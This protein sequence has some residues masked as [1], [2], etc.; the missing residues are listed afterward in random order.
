MVR[1][2]I[3][4]CKGYAESTTAVGQ[5]NPRA[6]GMYVV[7]SANTRLALALHAAQQVRQDLVRCVAPT[8]GRLAVQRLYAH[9]LHERVHAAAA[10]LVALPAQQARRHLRTGERKLHVPF[11]DSP[12]Q[13]RFGFADRLRPVIR[14]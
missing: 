9:T 7:S 8:R 3:A 11:V 10:N 5:T 14:A 4:A 2:D 1:P 13:Q 6:I 12:H